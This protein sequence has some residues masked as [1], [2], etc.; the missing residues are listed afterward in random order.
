[1]FC[2]LLLLLLLLECKLHLIMDW[3][4]LYRICDAFNGRYRIGDG[5]GEGFNGK[6]NIGDEF[7]WTALPR[8]AVCGWIVNLT[9]YCGI[10][11]TDTQTEKAYQINFGLGDT[12]QDRRSLQRAVSNRKRHRK[13]IQVVIWSRCWLQFRFVFQFRFRLRSWFWL[14]LWLNFDFVFDY[15]C[16]HYNCRYSYKQY[17]II[18]VF[19]FI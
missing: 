9:I 3:M 19:S 12:V 16:H 11:D 7:D 13:R 8:L 1:M 17:I 15:Y 4:I 10:D 18:F 5:I 2:L 6:G 14:R